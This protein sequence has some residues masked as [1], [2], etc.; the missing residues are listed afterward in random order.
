MAMAN[1]SDDYR[2]SSSSLSETMKKT[3]APTPPTPT[4]TTQNRVYRQ[5]GDAI[6][7]SMTSATSGG[8]KDED[9]VFHGVVLDIGFRKSGRVAGE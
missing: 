6:H 1:S 3:P 9:P 5:A 8:D 4:P 2:H 7:T